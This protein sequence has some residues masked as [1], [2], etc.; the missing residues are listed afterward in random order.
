MGA[1]ERGRAP[2]DAG[3]GAQPLQAGDDRCGGLPR[4]GGRLGPDLGCLLGRRFLLGCLSFWSGGPGAVCTA[5]VNCV[6][7]RSCW[8]GSFE[9]IRFEFSSWCR[10]SLCTPS[11]LNQ[12]SMFVLCVL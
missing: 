11:M 2:A 5:A 8:V 12:H 6:L 4:A 9:P 1:E 7:D 10:G 3:E